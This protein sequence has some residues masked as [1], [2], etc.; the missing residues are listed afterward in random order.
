MNSAQRSCSRGSAYD[1]RRVNVAAGDEIRDEIRAAFRERLI[2]QR[3]V[4]MPRDAAGPALEDV[5]VL[6]CDD[7]RQAVERTDVVTLELRQLIKRRRR[8]DRIEL[9][10]NEHPVRRRRP[11]GAEA[12]D[13]ERDGREDSR[14]VHIADLSVAIANPTLNAPV[15]RKAQRGR[16]NV[17][18]I[19]RVRADHEREARR[20]HITRRDEILE[21]RRCAVEVFGLKGRGRAARAAI[22]VRS[23]EMLDIAR[24]EYRLLGIRRARDGRR[25]LVTS[26]CREQHAA[27]RNPPR[28]FR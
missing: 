22:V 14:G 20:G 16:P 25:R 2:E 11:A 4:R 27:E 19:T 13:E 28:R 18:E 26:A 15:A 12:P 23:P 6:V 24:D 17:G 3:L 1:L 9:E 5:G 21:P 8:G 10:T 7:H